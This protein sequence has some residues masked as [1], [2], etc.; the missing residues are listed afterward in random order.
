[1]AKKQK[2]KKGKASKDAAAKFAKNQTHLSVILEVSRKTIQ[3]YAKYDGA[4]KARSDGRLDVEDWRAFLAKQGVIDDDVDL[5]VL[6]KRNMTLQNEKIEF[7]NQVA[8]EKF[9]SV[10]DVEKDTANLIAAA[11]SVLLTG[12]SSLAPQVIGVSIAEAELILRQWLHDALAKLSQNPLG[13]LG[14]KPDAE[15]LEEKA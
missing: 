5:V 2:G 8:R 14:T 6:K 10:E 7:Q 3:R 11:K 15:P 9:V 1:M 12:P 13:T 4:P